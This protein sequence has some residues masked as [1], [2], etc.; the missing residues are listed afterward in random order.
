MK[1]VFGIMLVVISL[2]VQGQRY[3]DRKILDEIINDFQNEI[4]YGKFFAIE[5]SNNDSI[6]TFIV[7]NIVDKKK[8]LMPDHKYRISGKKIFLY[9]GHKKHIGRTLSNPDSTTNDNKNSDWF[10]DASTIEEEFY[11]KY[12][13]INGIDLVKEKQDIPLLKLLE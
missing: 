1:V 4:G 12:V 10:L 7:H 2:N 9:T 11:R 6:E 8:E 5:Y 3:S 13:L